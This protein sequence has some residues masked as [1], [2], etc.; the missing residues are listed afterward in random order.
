MQIKDNQKYHIHLKLNTIKRLQV[1]FYS[2]ISSF[3]IKNKSFAS[4]Y[5]L[6]NSLQRDLKVGEIGRRDNQVVPNNNTYDCYPYLS[7]LKKE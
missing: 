6:R 7:K 4:L 5:Y 3:A 2:F 1:I